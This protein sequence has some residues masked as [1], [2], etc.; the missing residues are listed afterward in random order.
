MPSTNSYRGQQLA[1]LSEAV[2][3]LPPQ[4][5]AAVLPFLVSLMDVPFK[6]DVAEAIRSAG[7]QPTP[8]EME[9]QIED[10]KRE[11]VILAGLEVKARELELKERKVESEIKGLDAKSVQI[12]VQAAYSAMQ[13]GAQVAQMPMI[14]PVST[15]R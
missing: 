11:A 10:A 3:S 7:Q 9:R 6:H 14:A 2:K 8:E 15:G 12:G 4:Y 1:A 13:A 5:Q